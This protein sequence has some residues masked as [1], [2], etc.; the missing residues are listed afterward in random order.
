MSRDIVNLMNLVF[1]LSASIPVGYM[2]IALP[3][4]SSSIVITLLFPHSILKNGWMD[5]IHIWNMDLTGQGMPY[6]KMTLNS[7]QEHNYIEFKVFLFCFFV[8]FQVVSL[9]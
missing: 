7:H 5:Y 9:K 6:F 3:L 1:V 8:L 4:A 2:G